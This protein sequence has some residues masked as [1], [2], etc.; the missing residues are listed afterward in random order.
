MA[1]TS[2]VKNAGEFQNIWRMLEIVKN[3]CFVSHLKKKP[4]PQHVW[5]IQNSFT[6]SY[7]KFQ[8]VF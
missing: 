4:K 3:T 5:K 2:I 1:A 7:L 8:N 6:F